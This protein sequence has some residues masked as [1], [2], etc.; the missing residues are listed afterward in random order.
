[1][2]T[3]QTEWDAMRAALATRFP[4]GSRVE[5]VPDCFGLEYGEGLACVD[6]HEASE[7]LG[8]VCGTVIDHTASR[9]VFRDAGGAEWT[10]QPDSLRAVASE[11]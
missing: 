2:T 7:T 9:V 1:M 6:N 5:T 11:G 8:P 3:S 4:V 10:M